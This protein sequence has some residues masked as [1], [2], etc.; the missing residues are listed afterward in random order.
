[1]NAD[2]A[3]IVEDFIDGFD[4]LREEVLPEN[5]RLFLLKS[6]G[7]TEKFTVVFE[8][9]KGWMIEPDEYRAQ[10]ALYIAT[11]DTDFENFIAQTSFVGCG[12]LDFDSDV[13]VFSIDPDRRDVFPPSAI[14]PLWKV[15]LTREAAMRFRVPFDLIDVVIP[16]EVII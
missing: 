14:S 16:P 5:V 13:D 3:D 15:F 12:V 1:M 9:I 8:V 11:G 7:Q 6:A 10:T 2:I 4:E